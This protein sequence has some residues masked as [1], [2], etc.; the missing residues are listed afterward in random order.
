MALDMI[1]E[2]QQGSSCGKHHDQK[3][4]WG[5]RV[6]FYLTAYESITEGSQ[7]RSLEA[8]REAEATKDTANW[9][10]TMACLFSLISHSIQKHQPRGST[11]H[12]GWA[13]PHQSPME[14]L[15]MH[16]RLAHRPA[17]QR[18]FLYCGSLLSD[19]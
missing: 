4:P 11:I 12:E 1:T 13:L 7:G 16:Y 14:I 15:K 6:L 3:Q 2:T 10:V 8:E 17:L 5:E 18:H 9:L 19:N